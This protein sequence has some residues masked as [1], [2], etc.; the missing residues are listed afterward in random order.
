MTNALHNLDWRYA[1]KRYDSTKK[2][3]A[4]QQHLIKESLRLSPSSFGLQPYKFIHV[5]D[6]AIREQLRAAAW[7]QPQI[8]EASDLFV[9]AALRSI[10][11]HYIDRFIAL[12]AHAYDTTVESLNEYRDMIVGSVMGKSEPARLEWMKY[13]VYIPLG[14]ALAVAAEHGIDT[15][16]MEGFDPAS[17]DTILGLESLN[18]TSCVLLAA[19]FRSSEDAHQH[20]KKVRLSENDLFIKK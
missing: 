4:D 5:T 12:T 17:F 7:G 15:S 18:L 1:T 2:L 14:V 13:Q 19:G 6:P 3:S 20:Y 8:T 10:D 9:L 16:P 11:E